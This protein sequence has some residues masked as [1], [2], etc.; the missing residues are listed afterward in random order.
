MIRYRFLLRLLVARDL[1][2]RYA[3]SLLGFFW[4]FANSLWQ[5]VLYSLVFSGIMRIRLSGEGTDNFPY[6]LFSGLLCWM[7]FNE[8]AQKGT[9]VVV[10][11]AE[12][13]KKLHFPSEILVLATTV[14]A[15]AHMSIAFVVFFFI[16]LFSEGIGWAAGPTFLLALASQFALTAGISLF[17]ASGYVFLRDLQHAVALIFSALFYLA[18]IVYPISL[19]PDRYKWA[20]EA[21]PLST[22]LAAYRAF[23]VRSEPPPIGDVTILLAVSLVTLGLGLTA[24]RRL[25]RRFSDE[26]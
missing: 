10:E 9:Q 7:A 14:S 1:Q 17:L 2:A 15:L 13:V 12:L 18:P 21:N 20:I 6:F 23:L 22:I 19:V 5:L 8:G 3:G 24:Y 25:A 11:N 26:L 16:R 4:A